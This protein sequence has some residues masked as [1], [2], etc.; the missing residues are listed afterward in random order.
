MT[1]NFSVNTKLTFITATYLTATGWYK[2]MDDFSRNTNWGL[3]K[4]C[5]F[6]SVISPFC[7]SNVNEYGVSEVP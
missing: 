2:V 5:S 6:L 1:A 3:R 7:P 4:G